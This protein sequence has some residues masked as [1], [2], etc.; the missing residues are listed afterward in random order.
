MVVDRTFQMTSL[1]AYQSCNSKPQHCCT[2]K[3][4]KKKTKKH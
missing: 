4:R 2:G 1:A 3:M